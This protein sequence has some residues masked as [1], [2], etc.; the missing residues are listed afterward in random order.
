MTPT[1][2][3]ADND[4]SRAH[5]YELLAQRITG[6]VEPS[7]LSEDMLRGHADEIRAKSLYAEHYAPVRDVGFITEMFGGDCT[8]FTLGYSP[9]GL[10]GTDGLIESK[11]RRQKFQVQTALEIA[12]GKSAPAEYMLQIQTGLLVTGR[13]WC[14]FI[15]YSGGLPCIVERVRADQ[16]MQE[17]ILECCAAFEAKLAVMRLSYDAVVN[18]KGWRM[19]ERSVDAGDEITLGADE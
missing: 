6:Y 7:Y 14:D 11:S 1:S 3:P 18:V 13:K 5:A 16:A 8:A 9:D 15:S 12:A 17:R 10:V 19:T 2:K 4:K